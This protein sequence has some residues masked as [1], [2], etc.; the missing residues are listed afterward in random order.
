MLL[1]I[2]LVII[3]ILLI[4]NI[5]VFI[6][7]SLDPVC[8][9]KGQDNYIDNSYTNSSRQNSNNYKNPMHM[10][11]KNRSYAYTN[12]HRYLSTVSTTNRSMNR[13]MKRSMNNAHMSAL[14]DGY[15]Y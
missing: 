10:N 8:K 12:D 6:T 13:S 4:G 11:A 1:A 7:D 9:D 5:L 15:N 2:A 14:R 3:V